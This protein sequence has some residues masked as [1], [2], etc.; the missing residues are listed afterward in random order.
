MSNFIIWRAII[1]IALDE[2]GIKDHAETVI[3]V[4]TDADPLK[5]YNENQARAKHL[6]M[7]EVKDHVV[8]HIA[9]KKTTNEMWTALETMYQGSSI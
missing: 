3:V 2:Y 4:P 1:L 9:G 6:I 7:D 8:P 5:K